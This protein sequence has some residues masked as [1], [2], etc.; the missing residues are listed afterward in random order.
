MKREFEELAIRL[1]QFMRREIALS[2]INIEN[3][4]RLILVDSIRSLSSGTTAAP[5][6][7]PNPRDPWAHR[8]AGMTTARPLPDNLTG[9]SCDTCAWFV[10]P[11]GGVNGFGHCRRHAPTASGFPTTHETSWCGDHV[12]DENKAGR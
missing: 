11:D 12:S 3:S 6:T 2:G 4:L 1:E 5:G 9:E 7:E 10:E 8:S